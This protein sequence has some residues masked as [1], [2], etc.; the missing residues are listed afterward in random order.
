VLKRLEGKGANFFLALMLVSMIVIQA[1]AQQAAVQLVPASYTVS[2]VGLTFNVNVTVQGIENLYGYEFKLYY[3]NNVLN[4]TSATQGTFLKT[5]GVSTFFSV[6][7]FADNYNVTHGLLN[8]FCTRMGNV[9][10]VTGSGTLVIVT[11]KTT[12]TS[13][14]EALHLADVKL[15]DPNSTAIPST[16]VDGEIIV[17]PEFSLALIL[18]LLV[19]STLMAIAL[20]NRMRN[21]RVIF[22]SV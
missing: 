7:T 3:P 20:R 6:S 14:P 22:Q 10:G 11:F 21:Q 17:V 8:I 18:P 13:G 9:L 19:V 4:G 15:S 2:S 16:A 1:G 5:G 12:S